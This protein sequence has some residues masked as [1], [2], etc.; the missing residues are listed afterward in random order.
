[1]KDPY[2]I[3]CI[4]RTATLD[5]IRQAFRK[6]AK[7]L[8]PDRNPD[9]AAAI[10]RFKDVNVAYEILTDPEKRAMHERGG[11]G[12]RADGSGG[13]PWADREDIFD[14][15]FG[16]GDRFADLFGDIA[17]NRRGRG[18]TSMLIPGEDMAVDL[19]VSFIEAAVGALMPVELMTQITVDVRVPAG[20]RDS[21]M[22]TIRGYGFPGLG[23]APPGDLNVTVHIDPHPVLRRD[24]FNV[25]MDMEIDDERAR[26]SGRVM[27]PTIGGEMA[28]EVPAGVK[29]GDTLQL[30][31]M[32]FRDPVSGRRGDQLVSLVAASTEEPTAE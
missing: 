2:E 21:E 31:G 8:H 4:P 27:V 5:E 11:G 26:E 28:L 20:V 3:L 14:A 7:K 16:S 13:P 12:W 24:V 25:R 15:S 29:P 30:K 10:E 19:H 22:L 9:D 32:G 18:G 23:G 1:M 17:G 6:L